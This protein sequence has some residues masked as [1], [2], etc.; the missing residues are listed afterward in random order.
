MKPAFTFEEIREIENKII[1]QD[2]VPSIVLMENAGKNACDKLIDLIP[3][4]DEYDIFVVCGKGNN[5]GDGYTL[6]RHFIIKGYYINIIQIAEPSGLKGD[7]LINYNVLNKILASSDKGELI[8]SYDLKFF[9]DK[10]LWRGKIILID[11]VLG[12][13]IRGSLEDKYVKT[14]SLINSIRFKNKKMKVVSLDVPSGLMSGEQV[15]TMVKA[16]L[17]ISMGTYKTELLF[18]EGKE[19]A[20][21]LSVVPIGI[22]DGLITS[23]DSGNKKI[24]ELED[25]KRLFPK[26]KKTSYKYSNGKVLIIGG[27]KGLSGA[28]AMSSL[29]ALKS[30][31]GGVV[32]AI[33]VSISAVFNKALYEVMTVELEETEEGTIR[34]DQFDKLKKRIDWADTVLLGPGISTNNQT[35][36][37]VFEVIRNSGKNLVID[38]DALNILS[39]DISVLE[40]RKFNNE[41]ILTPHPGEFSRLT[42][43]DT[44]LILSD[45]FKSLRDFTEKYKINCALKSETTINCLKSGEIFINS[46]GDQNLA[47]AGSGDILS[48][49]IASV[50]S[51]TGEAA[52]A[53]ICGNYLHGLCAQMYS[54][55]YGN[56]QSAAP[57][58]IIKLIPKTITFL[59]S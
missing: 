20:G 47:T 31:A 23:Y 48:G 35:K 25:V 7:A 37:F 46:S 4:I 9:E 39:S 6:A 26:R 16:D 55:K 21:D 1:N 2:N 15:N 33:P 57:Q 14:I 24:I 17:T 41:I 8:H 11:A 50:F 19:N 52:S 51:R 43:I 49:V 44:K 22:S 3:D 56:K 58:D 54:K 28:V 12:T 53:L 34:N 45:R 30:G 10:K 29:S 36:E 13:G 38:A 40:N 59:L 32:A 5:A 42:G 18:G 27:S